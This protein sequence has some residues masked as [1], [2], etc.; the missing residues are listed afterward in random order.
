MTLPIPAPLPNALRQRGAQKGPTLNMTNPTCV[1]IIGERL[2][3]RPA[4][5]CAWHPASAFDLESGLWTRRADRCVPPGHYSAYDIR[6]TST[7]P[8]PCQSCIWLNDS[9]PDDWALRSR[10]IPLTRD[11]NPHNNLDE[12][13]KTKIC[14]LTPHSFRAGEWRS[15]EST[16]DLAM[17]NC[18]QELMLLASR[19]TSVCHRR[20]YVSDVN[21]SHRSREPQNTPA[22][23]AHG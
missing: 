15:L 19:R 13:E 8:D 22:A 18:L 5:L 4:F 12:I 7:P 10:H 11:R 9:A 20:S 14:T 1:R 3:G 17:A 16:S 6:A 2:P 21:G 23:Q